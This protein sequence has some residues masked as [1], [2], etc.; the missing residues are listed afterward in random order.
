MT[1]SDV[2]PILQNLSIGNHKLV[3][4]NYNKRVATDA[5]KSK[6]FHDYNK[7]S[8]PVNLSDMLRKAFSKYVKWPIPPKVKET[9][10]NICHKIYSVSNF[11]HKQ[12]KFD[13]VSCAFCD[14]TDEFTD[15]LNTYFLPGPFH[16]GSGVMLETG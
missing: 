8:V 11:L 3:D 12:F 13:Q 16:A 1:Y 2:T 15:E 14:F 10:F 6:L 7:N 4:K 9:H 5:F